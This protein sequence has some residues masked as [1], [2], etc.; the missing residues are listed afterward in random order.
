MNLV[1]VTAAGLN[2]CLSQNEPDSSARRV[3]L[4]KLY[5]EF[6]MIVYIV[7]RWLSFR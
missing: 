7:M 3:V 4:P 5:G 6:K 1:S 2:K